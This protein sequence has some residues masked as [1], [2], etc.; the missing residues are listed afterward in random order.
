MPNYFI[1]RP[2]AILNRV[3]D[4]RAKEKVVKF[5]PFIA[6]ITTAML[7]KGICEHCLRNV[8]PFPEGQ[9]KPKEIIVHKDIEK[10]SKL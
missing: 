10:L 6:K 3:H 2:G 5:I 9:Q 4:D 7:A 1:Y 8:P